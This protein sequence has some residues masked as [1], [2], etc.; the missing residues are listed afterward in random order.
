MQVI[1][2]ANGIIGTETSKALN[3]MGI[4]LRQVSRNPSKVNESDEVFSADLTNLEK[5]I[6][7]VKGCDVAYL[8]VGLEYKI[9]VWRKMWPQIMTNVIDACSET[10]CNL[11]FFDNVYMYGRVKGPM[12][13]ETPY[14]PSSKKGEVRAMIAQ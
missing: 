8:C 9:A 6:E 7:A 13:E 12:T 2:G 10:N 11:V 1:L 5:V 3:E 14:K 4:Q